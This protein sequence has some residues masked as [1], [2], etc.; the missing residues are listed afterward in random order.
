MVVVVVVSIPNSRSGSTGGG[1]GDDCGS[2]D[3]GRGGGGHGGGRLG[4]DGVRDGC[5]GGGGGGDDCRWAPTAVLMAAAVAGASIIY[6]NVWAPKGYLAVRSGAFPPLSSGSG[7][8]AVR[9]AVT[10][11]LVLSA[12]RTDRDGGWG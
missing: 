5:G 8:L 7:G 11:S 6:T 4:G 12:A 3:L 2:R 9:V 10:S 1:R